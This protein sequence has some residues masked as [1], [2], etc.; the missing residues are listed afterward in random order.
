MVIRMTCK[1]CIYRAMCYKHEHYGKE[2][3]KPCEMFRNK[4]DFVEVVR[5][6]DCKHWKRIAFDNIFECDFGICHNLYDEIEKETIERD[7][8]SDGER[9]N[10]EKE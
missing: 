5:C 2:N 6:R 3:E 10:I 9:K 8:C 4:A 7:Y 1:D